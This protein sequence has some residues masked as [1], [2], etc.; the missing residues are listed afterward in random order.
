MEQ[1]LNMKKGK[2][3][4]VKC[5][6]C[7]KEYEKYKSQLIYKNKFCSRKCRALFG[8][9]KLRN[10]FDYKE[11]QRKLIKAKG[12]RPPLHIGEN[13]W[14]WKGGISKS[15][16]G[17]DYKYCQWRKDVL[18]KYNFT[19]QKCGKRGVKL[20][21]H[22]IIKWSESE[23]LRYDLNNGICLCYECHMKIHGLNKGGTMRKAGWKPKKK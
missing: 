9:N 16:R 21:S 17:E 2:K 4:R 7:S 6:Y 18:A 15:N 1:S 8:G 19:C 5:D 22:H 11:R 20:S 13:H 23:E 14:N 3:E 10:D 12:N